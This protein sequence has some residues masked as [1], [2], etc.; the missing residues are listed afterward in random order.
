[1]TTFRLNAT[2][3]PV[4]AMRPIVSQTNTFRITSIGTMSQSDAELQVFYLTPAPN[5]VLPRVSVHPYTNIVRS[6]TTITAASA[7]AAPAA[8]TA[9]PTISNIALNNIQLGVLPKKILIGARKARTTIGPAQAE[10]WYPIQS[11]N[12]TLNN[13]SGLLSNSSMYQLYQMSVESGIQETSWPVW[14]GLAMNPMAA[15]DGNVN[16]VPTAGGFVALD[17]AKHLAVDPMYAPSSLGA[18]NFYGYVTIAP[19]VAVSQG[20]Q[21]EICVLFLNDNLLVTSYG[22]SSIYQGLF[23]KET[24]LKTIQEAPVYKKPFKSIFG[25][26]ATHWMQKEM[27]KLRE[28][29][30]KAHASGHAAGMASGRASGSSKLAQYLSK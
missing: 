11:V 21:I 6:T 22:S 1:M 2:F 16:L 26:S 14:S 30:D 25:G 9:R 23:D 20:D 10:T 17:V 12:L 13:R 19:Q 27:R 15:T 3:L 7:T 8:G 29:E 4:S 5:K 18:F 24:V 28:I